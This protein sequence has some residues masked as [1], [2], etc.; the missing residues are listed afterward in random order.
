VSVTVTSADVNGLMV[1]ELGF[2]PCYVQQPYEPDA[3][4]VAVVLG[5]AMEKS[6]ALRTLSFGMGSALTM[7]A[8]TRHGARFGP[9]GARV[10][11]VKP[12]EQA[13]LGRVGE[14]RGRGFA[15][16][17]CRLAAELRASDA[18]APLAAEG[19]ALQLLAA[20]SREG[21]V[22]RPSARKPA[23]LSSAEEILR[24]RVGDCIR[25]SDLAAEVDVHPAHL[26]REFRSHY[27]VSVGEYGR[28]LRLSWAATEIASGTRP[29]AEIAAAAGF[30]DQ[31]HFTRLFGRYIGMTPAGYRAATRVPR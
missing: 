28:R 5:G 31:S 24:A 3:S 2:P 17:A 20:A 9:S 13:D 26:A 23:W 29:L 11:I 21:S 16:L 19:L 18:A 7:A 22:E 6:F 27:G 25:L 8:G 30:A 14:L 12:R 4:Y 1:S 15:W 10:L